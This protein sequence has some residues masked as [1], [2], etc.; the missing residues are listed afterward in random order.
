MDSKNLQ[1]LAEAYNRVGGAPREV[2]ARNNISIRVAVDQSDVF[3]IIENAYESVFCLNEVETKETREG[4]KYKVR[5]KDKTTGSSYIRFATR[6]KIAELRANPNIASVELTDATPTDA[7]DKGVS[8]GRQ[9]FNQG[10]NQ[11]NSPTKSLEQR[12]YEK[13]KEMNKRTFG[14]I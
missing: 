13:E 8:A 7:T 4:T 10:P 6:E 3:N 12:R 11:N 5:V 9:M 1:S 14:G 2:D